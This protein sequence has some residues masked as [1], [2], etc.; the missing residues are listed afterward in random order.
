MLRRKVEEYES[1]AKGN[2]E[3]AT[4]RMRDYESNSVFEQRVIYELK[5]EN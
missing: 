1:A 3:P 4:F 2:H 5:A